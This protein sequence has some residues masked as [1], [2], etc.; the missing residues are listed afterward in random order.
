MK[1]ANKLVK[2]ANNMRMKKIMKYANNMRIKYCQNFEIH[3]FFIEFNRFKPNFKNMRIGHS[4]KRRDS[5]HN[6]VIRVTGNSR[7]THLLYIGNSTICITLCAIC[8]FVHCRNQGGGAGGNA[9]TTN[10]FCPPRQF[11]K[12]SKSRRSVKAL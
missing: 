4:H 8:S 11:S 1:A 6:T 2:Y 12:L 7:F 5:T 3:M 10:L 9:P